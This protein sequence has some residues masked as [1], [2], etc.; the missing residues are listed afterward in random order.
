[1]AK[2]KPRKAT[3]RRATNRARTAPAGASRAGASASRFLYREVADRLRQRIA[4]GVHGPGSRIPTERELIRE[5][6]VSAITVRRAI[7]DLTTEGL[8]FGRQGLGTFVTDPRRI[9]RTFGPE[10]TRTMADDM[11]GLGIEHGFKERSLALMPS[12]AKVAALLGLAPETPVFRHDKALLADGVPVGID[13]TFLPRALG[14]AVRPRLAG[15]YLIDILRSL[16]VDLHHTDYEFQARAM[17]EDEAGAL[18][19]PAGFPVLAVRYT[20]IGRDGRAIVT[21]QTVSRADRFSYQFCGH[22]ELHADTQR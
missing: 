16:S 15:E 5:F 2:P 4:G 20:I 8:L 17:S 12:D 22:P 14:D 18:G 6:G 21:G 11:R 13:V 9:V 7:R 10:L 1:M 19:L 3:K